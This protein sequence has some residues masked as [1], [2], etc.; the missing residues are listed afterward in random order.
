[1]CPML[2]LEVVSA[3]ANK[4]GGGKNFIRKNNLAINRR[5]KERVTSE[6]KDAD[7]ERDG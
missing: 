6:Q 5:R 2:G 4:V 1:M 7:G 3:R